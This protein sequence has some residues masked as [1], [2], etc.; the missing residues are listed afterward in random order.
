MCAAQVKEKKEAS[1]PASQPVGSG[2]WSG[3]ELRWTRGCEFLPNQRSE[4]GRGLGLGLG[5]A[6][7]VGSKYGE[8]IP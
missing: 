8:L 5:K 1:Q 4:F 2:G 6:A 3:V 7:V